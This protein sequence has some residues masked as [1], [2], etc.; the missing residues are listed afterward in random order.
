MKRGF[1]NR[2]LRFLIVIAFGIIPAFVSQFFTKQPVTRHIHIR[3]FRY[4]KDPAVIRC[5]RGDTLHL[6]FSTDDTGH[7]FYLEEFDIDAKV[8]PA[9]NAVEVFKTSDPTQKSVITD[10]VVIIARHLG[11]K[12]YLVSRSN[13]RC[14]VWC[15]PMH[16]FESGKLI[17][18]PNTLLIFS[19]GCVIGILVL[20]L[21]S[22]FK[23]TFLTEN[24]ES[25]T[26]YRDI[27]KKSGILR[28]LVVSR[29]PQAIFFLLAMILVY[30]V[31]L[32]SLF[33]TKVSGRNL[34][35]LL[36]WA[37]WLFLLIALMTPFLGRFWCTVCPLPFF[38]DLLQRKS[39]FTPIEGTKG[40]YR[41]HFTGLFLKWPKR[42]QNNW[43]KLIVLLTLTT[44]SATLVGVPKVTGAAVI[45]L[46]IVPTILAS[47]FELRAFCRY[48][49]PVSGFVG[50]FSRMSTL[51]LRNKSQKTCDRCKANYCQL[52]SEKGWACPYGLNVGEMNENSDCG[53]CLECTRS[54]L[55]KNVTVYTRP[56]AS[57]LGTRDISEA[58]L[59]I[60]IFTLAI[61]YSVLYQGHWAIVR[62]YVN[63][64]DKGNWNLFGRYAIIVWTA[65]LVIMPGLI[66]GLSWIGTRLAKIGRQTKEVFLGSAGSLLPLGLMLWIAFVIPMLFV[67]VTFIKQS[68]SDPFGWGWDFFGTANI[69]WHQFMPGL[70]PWLQA[71]LIL[72]G[73]YL[74]LRNLKKTPVKFSDH[75]RK[76]MS[77]TFPVGL[78]LTCST[79]AMIFFFTN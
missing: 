68:L 25:E 39:G 54:C 49:C 71:G 35:V 51:A 52:G 69:P 31:L 34:G 65:T 76:L 48:L 66:Y 5:N 62:D 47:V 42:L 32:T 18:G 36:M 26:G 64:L 53:L 70:V 24:K 8:S 19:L 22:F 67:N 75:K 78:F 14:H 55:Y 44:F 37:I 12:N 1:K 77:I 17:I 73:L 13:Y 10:E 72:Y 4:G 23:P 60:G 2:I 50:P 27:L 7:S 11:L 33:G 30:V 57:E 15:G 20:W 41:N 58:W 9:R 56:F 79:V 40:K 63:V 61:V 45:I 21:I 29:W 6:T 3:N 28:K 43:P 16:A 59:T 46:L 38:G 74:S